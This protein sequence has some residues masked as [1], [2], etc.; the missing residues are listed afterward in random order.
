MITNLKKLLKEKTIIRYIVI[1]GTSYVIELTV[2]L[3]LA[4]LLHLNPVLSVGISF[5]VGLIMSFFLQK[6]F[7]FNNKTLKAKHLLWQS[8][9]YG[10]LVLVNYLFTLWFVGLFNSV[11]GL[12]GS[13]TIALIITTFWNYFVYKYVLFPTTSS[14]FLMTFSWAKLLKEKR[15]MLIAGSVILGIFITGY[16][17]LGIFSRPMADDLIFLSGYGLSDPVANFNYVYT[18]N[19]R[20]TAL[21]IYL[22]GFTIPFISELA[23]LIT[24][25][26]LGS[27]L[28][29]LMREILANKLP[30]ELS[31]IAT[32]FTTFSLLSAF[33]ILTP[34]PPSSIF[35][36]SA[37]VVHVWSY[38][39]ILMLVAYLLKLRKNFGGHTYQKRH[40][41]LYPIAALLIGLLG[42]IPALTVIFFHIFVIGLDAARK[43]KKYIQITAA[44]LSGGIAAF[45]WLYFAPASVS[46]RQ[47][48]E[49]LGGLTTIDFIKN[50]P[51]ELHHNISEQLPVLFQNIYILVPV[52]FIGLVFGLYLVRSRSFKRQEVILYTVVAGLLAVFHIANFSLTYV[53][54]GYIPLRIYASSSLA[55]ILSAYLL[56]FVAG[57]LIKT[58]R[59]LYKGAALG[60]IVTLLILSII[61]TSAYIPWGISLGREMHSHAKAWDARDSYIKNQIKR[62]NCRIMAPSLP[63]GDVGDINKDPSYWINKEGMEDYYRPP[64]S[65]NYWQSCTITSDR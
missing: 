36:F 25:L 42:E 49:E 30:A 27:G 26:I 65:R 47:G 32:I 15:K 59:D 39:F 4:K 22:L 18:V 8:V 16:I 46:R 43:T 50:L 17:T 20:L 38:G 11:M 64:T 5:W 62:G 45:A 57:N 41:L 10:A 51:R 24:M 63:I 2:L 60:S 13:R 3:I 44:G 56:G 12:I 9:M 52:F 53:A 28:Y 54:G 34:S 1:G 29:L 37:A 33:A 19:G 61:H 23:A 35:W 31:R 14:S 21:T 48:V 58:S 6:F 7:A 40:S 55:L